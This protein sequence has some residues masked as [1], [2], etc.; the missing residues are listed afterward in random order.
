M[1]LKSI[2]KIGPE[3]FKEVLNKFQKGYFDTKI[4]ILFK[5]IK[6]ILLLSIIIT[7]LTFCLTIITFS[8]YD[9]SSKFGILYDIY[10][11]LVP[12]NFYI[13]LW[14]IIPTI[15][16]IFLLH[17]LYKYYRNNTILF[18]PLLKLLLLHF[19]LLVMLI[20]VAV[21]RLLS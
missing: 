21:A 7:L 8:Y 2:I 10:S 1:D 18:N 4:E 5:L 17:L 3:K 13:I 15:L 16:I 9:R 11:I 6:L 14:G 20:F 12:L 19:I